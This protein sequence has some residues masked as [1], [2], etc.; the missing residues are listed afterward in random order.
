MTDEWKEGVRGVGGVKPIWSKVCL[1]AGG[2]AVQAEGAD[3]HKVEK[4]A[5][6][7]S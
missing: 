5:C 2:G 3:F 1:R 6:L 4:T 7:F